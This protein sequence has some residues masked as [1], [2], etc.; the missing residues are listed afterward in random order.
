M[1]K[2]IK[3]KW[4][5][6][7]IIVVAIL[8]FCY[9]AYITYQLFQNPTDTF[10]IE[11]GSLSQEEVAQG[12]IIRNETVIKGENYK[13]GMEQIKTE[14]EKVAKGEA[15]FRYFTNGEEQ[16]VQKIAELDTKIAEAWESENNIFSSDIKLLEE[17]ITKKL[18]EV[19]EISDLQKI[20]EY[21][22]DINNAITKKA[23][24]AGELSPSGSYLKSLIDERSIYENQLNSG[25][26]YVNAPS[27]G[28][29]SYRVDG[30][31]EVLT[32]SSFGTLSKNFLEDFHLKT[33]EIITT[34]EESGKV[35]DNFSCYIACVLNSEISK[36]AEIGD[37]V[38]LRLSN[39]KE[40]EATIEYIAQDEEE[41]NVFVFKIERYVEELINYRKISLEVIWWNA[42]GL[43]VPNEAIKWENDNLAYV[44]RRRAG[45]DDKKIYVKVL[46][47]NDQY[48]IITNY[49]DS[50][51]LTEKGVRQEE[52][53]N[54]TKIALYDEIVL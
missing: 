3:D 20:K 4:K 31:E 42:E 1:K 14:G 8:I 54:R 23:K 46:K 53:K 33:G 21:K 6:G 47:A 16:L 28:I 29:V 26:E 40:V 12:Y 25:S 18:D 15:V 43:K 9:I 38:S 5:K 22:K 44:V 34:S 24:I 49:T 37:M 48:A 35:I 39:E 2:E 30:L 10:V 27:S 52:V 36:Q 11:N 45:Y 13:N 51:E 32:P 41:G 19:Y 50:Q 17:N 7:V